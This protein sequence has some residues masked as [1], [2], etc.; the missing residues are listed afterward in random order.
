MTVQLILNKLEAKNPNVLFRPQQMG[1]ADQHLNPIPSNISQNQQANIKSHE[2]NRPLNP[3]LV[4][5]HVNRIKEEKK[6]EQEPI[7]SKLFINPHQQVQD[8]KMSKLKESLNN[9][10]ELLS[11]ENI[12]GNLKLQLS[13]KSIEELLLISYNPEEYVNTLTE[14]LRRENLESLKE[15]ERIK[16]K[17]F[18]VDQNERLKEEYDKILETIKEHRARYEE[19]EKTLSV[20]LTRKKEIEGRFGLPAFV[21]DLNRHI[22]SS[23]GRARQ[24]IIS[25]FLSK[26]IDF[27]TFIE[28][29]KPVSKDYHYYSMIRDKLRHMAKT[30]LNN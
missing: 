28:R 18:Y 20:L 27:D 6:N 16:G 17:S 14:N 9:K 21:E 15:V 29:F 7:N 25:D 1:N 26:R 2:P 4:D 8:S 24:E 5:R 13:G 10:E 30:E 19:N 22:D 12:K 23:Y 3:T 11:E